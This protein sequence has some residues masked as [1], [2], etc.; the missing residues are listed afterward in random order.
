MKECYE[1]LINLNNIKKQIIQFGI[2]EEG[3]S[4]YNEDNQLSE[5]LN[6]DI[7]TDT[8]VVLVVEGLS[9]QITKIKEKL[10]EKWEKFKQKFEKKKESQ[11]SKMEQMM[12]DIEWLE[13]KISNKK[14]DFEKTATG[15]SC[16]EYPVL[17]KNLNFI[18]KSEHDFNNALSIKKT[19]EG[20]QWFDAINFK[21]AAKQLQVGFDFKKEKN[22]M[23]TYYPI[24]GFRYKFYGIKEY[25]GY[26][27]LTTLKYDE[28]KVKEVIG[29]FKKLYSIMEQE[30]VANDK[31]MDVY[32]NNMSVI[33]KIDEDTNF[34]LFH[35]VSEQL[36]IANTSLELIEDVLWKLE[37]MID[38][39]CDVFISPFKKVAK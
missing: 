14:I 5:L 25:D 30:Q 7:T 20:I 19:K 29:L 24:K 16:V 10:K 38:K 31:S 1:V 23:Y 3:L 21:E 6:M 8:E 13:D 39:N 22:G 26:T 9:E 32:R 37:Q 17:K 2:T 4:V 36:D 27:D 35:L 34:K 11:L 28:N 15:A 18:I 33:D 12:V